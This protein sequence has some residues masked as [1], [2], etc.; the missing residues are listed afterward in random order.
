MA[1][2][3]KMYIKRIQGQAFKP[4][5]TNTL[6]H[7]EGSI[8]LWICFVNSVTGALWKN[9]EGNLLI[10]LNVKLTPRWLKLATSWVFQ[11]TEFYNF[12][13]QQVNIKLELCFIIK[14]FF[15]LGRSSLNSYS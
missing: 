5:N 7:G 2:T 12:C 15:M 6:M 9:E 3:I 11:T 4:K 14:E 10:Q 1:P 13:Q 8:M